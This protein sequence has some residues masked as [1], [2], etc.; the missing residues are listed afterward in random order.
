[1]HDDLGPVV[2]RRKGFDFGGKASGKTP[3]SVFIAT[4]LLTI[5]IFMLDRSL[6]LGAA[7]GV[8]YV[9]IVLMGVWF[10]KVSQIF[11]LALLGSVM[12]V[13]GYYFSSS[14]GVFWVVMF[15][16]GLALFVIW[17][18]A[19]LLASRKKQ[20]NSLLLERDQLDDE[21]IKRTIELK[22]SE[23]RF[24]NFA[25]ASSDW[26]WEMDADLRFTYFSP[27]FDEITGFKGADWIGKWRWGNT[28]LLQQDSVWAS[29][30]RDLKARRS[31]KNYVFYLSEGGE[32]GLYINTSGIAL[33][34]GNGTFTGY[35]GSSNNITEQKLSEEKKRLSEERLNI[36]M[37]ASKAG[38]WMRDV[39]LTNVFWSDENY[40][41]LGYVPG[42]VEASYENW[43]AR[44]HPDDRDEAMRKLEHSVRDKTDISMD[45]RVVHP[46]GDIIWLNNVGKNL[47]G[48]DGKSR[49]LAGIQMDISER[50]DLEH[51]LSQSQRM[52]AV[53]QL[54]GGIAHDFNNLLGIMLG[55]A[56]LLKDTVHQDDK[57]AHQISA[58]LKAIERAASLTSRLLSFSRKQALSPK[59][60][61]ISELLAGLDDMLSRTLGETVSIKVVTGD[62]VWPVMIDPHQLEN[63][64]VNLSLNARD[65]MLNGG[66][67]TIECKNVT[68]DEDYTKKYDDVAPG[69]YICVAVSDNGTGMVMDVQEKVF[70]PFFTTKDVGKGSGLGLSMVYGFVIQSDG[71]ISVYSE[72]GEGTTIKLY[73]PRSMDGAKA[74]KNTSVAPDM[75]HGTERI[76]VV[77]DDDGVREI[78][79]SI[80]KSHGYQVTEAR[81]GLEAIDLLKL[82]PSF[83]LLF[84]D[85][86]LP[87]GINGVD[88][89][90][91]ALRLHPKIK[92]L[93]TTGYSENAVIHDGKLDDG[94]VLL[95][96]PYRQEDLLLNIRNSLDKS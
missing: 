74:A 72:L 29:H 54:T 76:L 17:M 68:L 2:G 69:E 59:T 5:I 36:A 94:V 6:P 56:E 61:N 85:V 27:R 48:N 88:I 58:I 44:L 16:R 46:N 39:P 78:P 57:T 75:P 31:F 40:R 14:G 9:L 43:V 45:Y 62:D 93:Y 11:Y 55:N 65:A 32:H 21:V 15:N 77:E 87:G 20:E 28:S 51:Q 60:T 22:E 86:I 82:G 53:G 92:I 30:L 73:L 64:L 19:F 34:D 3:I 35:R 1:M 33:F 63:V 83:D 4:L 70:E 84:T 13:V 24:K 81:G 38:Y 79:V 10:S 95:S 80:L 52:E 89:V 37:A 25:E 90:E 91:E 42:E 8:L 67:L 26:F 12:T 47:V 71:H 49:V 18:A 66:V 96:K 50:K 23:Q 7:A 41:L